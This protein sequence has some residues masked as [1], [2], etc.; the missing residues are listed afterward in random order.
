VR[1]SLCAEAIR[2]TGLLTDLMSDEPE[3]VGLLSLMILH[4]ARRAARVDA[5]G[6][7]VTLDEQDRELWDVGLDDR[8]I[9]ARLRE[10][11]HARAQEATA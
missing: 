7:L 4:D 2:L 1:H 5:H 11:L 10:T 9:D 6:D 3:A 8:S